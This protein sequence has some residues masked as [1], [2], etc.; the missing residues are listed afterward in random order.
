VRTGDAWLVTLAGTTAA[1]AWLGM[2][3]LGSEADDAS[4][5]VAV[6]IPLALAVTLAVLALAYRRPAL[7][8][9]AAA[10]LAACLAQRSMDGLTVPAETEDVHAEVTLVSDP[11]PTPGGGVR[12]DVSLDGRRL[13]LRAHRAAAAALRNRLAGERIIVVG[14][15]E[16]RGPY[17]RRVPHRHLGGRLRVDVVV[18]WYEGHGITRI[19]NGLRRTL[20]HGAASLSDRQQ[21]LL[22]GLI[23][24]DDRKQPSDLTHAFRGA[25][26]A[27]LLAVSGQNVAFLLTAVSPLLSRMRLAPRLVITLLLLALFAVMTRG[28][29]SV[30]RATAMAGIGA[31]SAATGRPSSGLRRLS[32]AVVAL[33]LCDPLLVS[34]LGFQLSVAG[35]AGIIVAARPIADHLPGPRV[36][37]LPAA[38]TVAAEIA[39]APVLVL[40]LGAVPLVSLPAN[41]LAAPAAGPVK[42]W[43]ITGGLAAGSLG[44]SLATLLHI[45]TRVLLIWLDHVAT[46]LED[47]PLGELR[48]GHV[49]LLALAWVLLTTGGRI[50]SAMLATALRAAGAAAVATALGTAIIAGMQGQAPEGH[51][52]VG[53]GMELWR[54]QRA[55]VVVIDGRAREDWLLPELRRHGVPRVDVVIVRTPANRAIAVA[56]RLREQWPAT[57]VLAPA[58]VAED[59]AGRLPGAITPDA[60]PFDLD[61]LRLSF[62]VARDRLEPEIA[63]ASWTSPQ[64]AVRSRP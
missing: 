3:R 59:V 52:E 33:L 34:S 19:A 43:G 62:D 18:G 11:Q 35:A 57:T 38:V 24:G 17:E 39:V 26:L 15:I 2:N 14:A 53:P 41:L 23:L 40:T 64:G 47:L 25:G 13:A 9:L 1:G 54:S 60:G 8:C 16:P 37:R 49:A 36:L 22:G 61:G 4:G 48:A 55:A 31:Y 6:R 32:L 46:R 20:D 28:E 51:V 7:V 50:G 21:G 42:L 63:L 58:V 45:P 27:H 12:A 29:P 10:V 44:G 30:L 56:A 5:L